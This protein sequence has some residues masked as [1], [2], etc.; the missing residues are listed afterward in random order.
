MGEAILYRKVQSSLINVGNDDPLRA[1]HL[2]NSCT[3]Q[4]NSSSAVH[5]H[6][7]ILG[8]QATPECM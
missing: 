5:Y 7:R 8:H 1:F 3:Q 6:G 4:T 2:R